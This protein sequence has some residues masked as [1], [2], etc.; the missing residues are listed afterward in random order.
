MENRLTKTFAVLAVDNPDE[1]LNRY[2]FSYCCIN[3]Q[4]FVCNLVIDDAE[5]LARSFKQ[6][7]FIFCRCNE[8]GAIFE[9]WIKCS[10]SEYVYKKISETRD[11]PND[12]P[13]DEIILNDDEMIETYY[14]SYYNNEIY[15]ENFD[16]NFQQSLDEGLTFAGRR[17]ARSR[18]KNK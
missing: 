8:D 18:L 16:F 12:I 2:S 17:N 7:R 5:S 14:N 4:Y 11:I 10:G 3:G 15:R 13:F 1:I 6:E 9:T